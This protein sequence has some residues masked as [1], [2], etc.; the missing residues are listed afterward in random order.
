MCFCNIKLEKHNL[1]WCKLFSDLRIDSLNNL[2]AINPS[3][4]VGDRAGFPEKIFLPK[5]NGKMDQKWAKNRFFFNI[6]KNF[7]INFYWIY[8]IIKTYIICCV[9]ANIP[10]LGK[11]LFLRYGPKYSQPIRLQDSLINYIFRANQWKHC[12]GVFLELDH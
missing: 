12:L 4:A 7:V 5:K 2:F 1:L 9:P 11:F 3:K 10:C 6:M 8:F